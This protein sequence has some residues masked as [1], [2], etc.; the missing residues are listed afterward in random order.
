MKKTGLLILWT[1]MVTAVFAEYHPHHILFSL[2]PHEAPLTPE[3]C[4]SMETPYPGLNTFIRKNN[5]VRIEPW[6]P[7]A[8]PDDRDGAV[9]L[10][11]I[12]RIVI[13][14]DIELAPGILSELKNTVSAIQNAEWEPVMRTRAVPDDPMIGNQWYLNKIGAREAWKLW[15][16]ANGEVP[17]KKEIVIAVVDDGVEYTHPDLW[18]SIWINQDEIPADVF[19]LADTD[20]DGFV[21]AAEAVAFCGDLNGDGKADLRDLL[22]SYSP[23]LTGGD[24]DGDGY[25]DNILG[26]DAAGSDNNPMPVNNSHGT[27]VAGLAGATT[28]NGTGVASVGYGVRVMPVKASGDD[29]SNSISHGY[30][31]I[32]CAAQ[33]GADIINLSWGGPGYSSYAQ[34]IINNAYNTYG[35]II[36]ASAGN[37]DDNGN[38]SDTPHYPSGYNNVVSVTAVSS[39]DIFSWASYGAADLGANFYGVDIAAPGENMLSTYLTKSGSYTY[40]RGTSMSSPLVASC[41]ALIKSAYPDSSNAW[42]IARLLD[43]TDPIDHLNPDYAGQLGTG[44]VNILRSLA[45]DKW[46]KL[47]YTELQT[48]ITEGDADSLLNPGERARFMVEIKNDSGWVAASEV[49]GILRSSQSGI[50]ITDS[51]ATWSTIPANTGA[52]NNDNGFEVLLSEDL[53]PA[54]YNFT[55]ELISNEDTDYPYNVSLTIPVSIYLDQAGFPFMAGNAVETS[56]VFTDID[57]NGFQDI[58]FA[59]KSGNVYIVDHRGELRDGFPLV[60]GDDVGGIAIDDIDLDGTLDLVITLFGKKVLVYDINGQFKWSRSIGGFITSMPAIGNLDAGPEKEIVFGANNQT[61]Y[62]LRHDSTDVSGFPVNVGQNIRRGVSLAD[63]NGDGRD[64]II[65]GGM[66]N[67]L[68]ILDG[69]GSVREGWPQDLSG[70]IQSEPYV[71]LTG[72]D[73]AVILIGNDRGDMYGFDPDGTQR[74]M[75]NGSGS[76]KAS[77]AVF[78]HN[79]SVYAAFGTGSGYIYLINVR[80][81]T[82]VENWPKQV[83]SPIEQSLAAARVVH[84][85]GYEQQI[86]AIG[87]DGRIHAYKMDGTVVDRFPIP[88]RY[89]SKSSL[90]IADIDGDGDLELIAGTNSGL[91]VIDLKH[92]A[93][94]VTWPM[95]RGEIAR[96]GS[97]TH[98]LITPVKEIDVPGDLVFELIGNAPNPFNSSTTITY[99]ISEPLSV[100]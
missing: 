68:S 86:L 31:G 70:T 78:G 47:S 83:G 55:L 93:G 36:V 37:G 15:D 48:F 42:L 88:T 6:I 64:A 50:T 38:P 75:I 24:T 82:L 87:G 33:A 22:H 62:A 21:T 76:V 8:R 49:R 10:N 14:P 11:R 28:N 91:S 60:L 66:G 72:I 2:Q 23:F 39:N 20:D 30:P 4:I 73:S 71:I 35:S 44:R 100:R 96:K 32:T 95:H 41:L 46:P 69:S 27:H 54:R 63:L 19:A 34:N 7:N 45:F 3:Q 77:P 26:W 1:M 52:W 16:I 98:T 29:D 80:E 65:F 89:L 85:S 74:F 5:A 12:Y 13:R 67:K 90:A 57:G 92:P 56:P 99:S 9:Y 40:L 25:I 58:I 81:G 97:S 94:P 17:G 79:G 84:E 53:P 59:D 43:H 61:L 51:V 18:Q